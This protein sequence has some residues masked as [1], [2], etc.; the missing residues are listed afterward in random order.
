MSDQARELAIPESRT[1]A[2]AA[3][4]LDAAFARFLR[5]DV[6]NGDASPDTVRGYGTQVA[7]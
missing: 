6:V 2:P 7:G 4:D 5:L 1:P 3:P